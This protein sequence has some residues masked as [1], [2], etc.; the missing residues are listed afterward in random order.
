MTVRWRGCC[1]CLLIIY[2]GIILPVPCS[3]IVCDQLQAVFP[4]D[5]I[6]R[7][8]YICMDPLVY[9]SVYAQYDMQ[10]GEGK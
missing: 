9:G 1:S 8:Y 7:R 3:L 10:A 5:S 6:S 2:L 4:C